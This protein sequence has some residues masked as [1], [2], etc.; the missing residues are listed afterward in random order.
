[1]KSMQVCPVKAK[2]FQAGWFEVERLTNLEWLK[3]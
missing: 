3:E 1:M 2:E